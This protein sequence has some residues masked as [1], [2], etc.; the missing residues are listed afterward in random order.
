MHLFLAQKSASRLLAVLALVGVLAVAAAYPAL[1]GEGQAREPQPV[2]L[3]GILASVRNAA[4][5]AAPDGSAWLSL[6]GRRRRG[7][8]LTIAVQRVEADGNRRGSPRLRVNPDDDWPVSLAVY[9]NAPC[10]G[11]MA[12]RRPEVRCLRARSWQRL[13]PLGSRRRGLVQI[14]MAGGRLYGLLVSGSLRRRFQLV[15]WGDRRW[16]RVGREI[17]EGG[18]ALAQ[19]GERRLGQRTVLQLGVT[20]PANRGRGRRYVLDWTGQQWQY[21]TPVAP[22]GELGSQTSGPVSIGERVFFAR[23][24]AQATPWWTFTAEVSE[25]GSPLAPIVGSP[26]NEGTGNAQGNLSF[27]AG[28]VWAIWQEHRRR[29]SGLAANVYASPIAG[30]PAR[31]TRPRQIWR[32]SNSPPSDI[33][34]VELGGAPYALFLR[35]NRDVLQPRLIPLRR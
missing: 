1:S 34:V 3:D 7:G 11:F 32:A 4:I 33:E 10:L 16:T 31:A 21:A 5:E 23:V 2:A 24:N 19:L 17:V 20:S 29:P 13:S 14:R 26:L 25:R 15:R 18:A 9:R 22:L 28:S 6:V 8:P 27:A 35:P 12:D 30:T